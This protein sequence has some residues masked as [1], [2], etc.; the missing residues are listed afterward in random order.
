MG[1]PIPKERKK[2]RLTKGLPKMPGGGEYYLNAFPRYNSLSLPRYGSGSM[3]ER[4][5]YI[6]WSAGATKV[7]MGA[8]FLCGRKEPDHLMLHHHSF[9][10]EPYLNAPLPSAPGNSSARSTNLLWWLLHEAEV[11]FSGGANGFDASRG[12]MQA[13]ENAPQGEHKLNAM[14]V[15]AMFQVLV[16]HFGTNPVVDLKGCSTKHY[17]YK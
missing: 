13:C 3:E 17:G 9:M 14:M 4:F 16:E 6:L 11:R 5:A 7:Y 10:V 1:T 15:C 8:G 12:Y 2:R